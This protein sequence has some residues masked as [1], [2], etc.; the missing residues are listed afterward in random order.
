MRV[1]LSSF[2]VGNDP[3]PLIR[4]AGQDARCAL[5]LNAL[6]NAPDAREQFRNSQTTALTELGFSVDEL[7]LRHYF[8]K[9]EQLAEDLKAFD[10][11]WINGGN[12]FILRKALHQS[13]LAPLLPDLLSRDEIVYAGFSAAAVI[14]SF[15][16]KGLTPS[17]AS[18]KP[19]ASYDD[20]LIWHG[21]NILPFAIVVH[22]ASDHPG[23]AQ[24]AEEAAY[25]QRNGIPHYLLH[26]GEALV[27]DG[28]T[29]LLSGWPDK[30]V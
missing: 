21:L 4:M 26:D 15:D 22:H 19:L 23:R 5:I 12:A 3:S 16:L 30:I 17:E 11:V 13:G 20:G 8:S 14:A 7:D 25:Y 28:A 29:T 24:A 18:Y 6:D 2:L 9:K 27:I 10:L 1:Y